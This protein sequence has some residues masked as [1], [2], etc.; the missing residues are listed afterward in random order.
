MALPFQVTNSKSASLNQQAAYSKI[1]T[2][3]K[4]SDLM[5]VQLITFLTY[6][7]K[8]KENTNNIN[9]IYQMRDI[10]SMIRDITFVYGACGNLK[11]IPVQNLAIYMPDL[12]VVAHTK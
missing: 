3:E 7:R 1:P 12:S 10:F 8:Y 6:L 2:S 4:I 9:D 5:T 11:C